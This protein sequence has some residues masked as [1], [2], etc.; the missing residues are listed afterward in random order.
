VVAAIGVGRLTLAAYYRDQAETSLTTD[1]Q[2][3]LDRAEQS[4][5]LQGDALPTLYA[6]AAAYARLDRYDAARRTLLEAIRYEPTNFLPRA[7]LGDL[8]TRRGDR[9]LAREAYRAAYR[10]NPRNS[11]LRELARQAGRGGVTTD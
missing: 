8:A 9:A 1:P 11:D 2:A 4:L 10:L 5:S 3:A 7:L 6:K